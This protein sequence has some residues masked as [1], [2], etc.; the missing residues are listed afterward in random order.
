[1]DSVLTSIMLE[2]ADTAIPS[3]DKLHC[4][5]H[6]A[7]PAITAAAAEA[8]LVGEASR[9]GFEHWAAV[10]ALVL[11][12][13]EG[14]YSFPYLSPEYCRQLVHELSQAGYNTNPDE[15]PEARIPEIVLLHRCKPLHDALS[16]LWEHTCIPLAKL[17]W[18]LEPSH[19]SIIQAA[20]Y[21]AGGTP[22]T[23]MHHD[24]DSDVTLVVNLGTEFKGGGT[25]V[26]AGLFE[27]RV[28]VPPLPV[29]HAMFF[30]GKTRIH[31]GLP[32][33]EGVRT[34]IVH[35]ASL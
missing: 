33:T 14:V 24:Q 6:Y 19:C 11:K 21:T 1:M 34:L 17:L 16:V 23:A 15:P 3:A 9:I 28:T 2:R 4:S 25:E 22:G 26:G 20:Q 32:V 31:R 13:G 35:W 29:G 27:D 12:H 7:L 8:E 10:E 30:L 18:N 5:L